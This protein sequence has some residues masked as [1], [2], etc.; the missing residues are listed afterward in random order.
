MKQHL[1]YLLLLSVFFCS[2]HLAAQRTTGLTMVA[3]TSFTNHSAYLHSLK[4]F[5]QMKFPADSLPE[6]V[7]RVTG[8]P[9]T[10]GLNIDVFYPARKHQSLPGILIIHGGGWRSGN[11]QQHHAMAA[12][13]AAKGFVCYTASYRL[14]THALYPA[15]VADLKAAIRWIKANAAR[16]KTDTSRIAVAGFSAGGQLAALIGATNNKP[17]FDTLPGNQQV[18]SRVQAIVCIDGVLA[19]IHPE[20]AEGNDSK[21]PSAATQWFGYTKTEKPALWYEASALTYAGA[22]TPPTLFINSSIP[23]FHGGR[24]D[25]IDTLKAHHIYT[26]VQELDNTPHTFCLFEPWFTP[27]VNYIDAFLK[28]VFG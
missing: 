5:P 3:D 23:R 17:E 15:A 24:N 8:I 2:T 18:S 14:S 13:L 26:E 16:W 12:Q 10:N 21:A 25:Y 22:G 27:T 4:N 20:S 6:G 28:K 9:Y 11:P 1:K 7:A 19:F